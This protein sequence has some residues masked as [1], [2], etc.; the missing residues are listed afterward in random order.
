MALS[1]C[2]VLGYFWRLFWRFLNYV[3]YIRCQL[4]QKLA[5][6]GPQHLAALEREYF[7]VMENARR[8]FLIFHFCHCKNLFKHWT[9]LS[10]GYTSSFV[11]FLVL[12]SANS[13]FFHGVVISFLL[14][15]TVYVL[16]DTKLLRMFKYFQIL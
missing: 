2:P 3:K 1:S 16:R 9:L 10:F 4:R 7:S 5:I 6:F 11:S 12:F 15:T 8:F 14:E 13:S